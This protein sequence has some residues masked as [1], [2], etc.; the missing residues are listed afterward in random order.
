MGSGLLS[1]VF[2]IGV[3]LVIGVGLLRFRQ[4]PE[5]SKVGL[6][7]TVLKNLAALFAP[8]I[9]AGLHKLFLSPTE[10]D[11]FQPYGWFQ[12]FTIVIGLP[13]FLAV[14]LLGQLFGGKKK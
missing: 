14:N 13:L 3:G 8:L 7:W 4:A 12:I 11:W 1:I 2:S 5:S 10:P 9:L 6:L